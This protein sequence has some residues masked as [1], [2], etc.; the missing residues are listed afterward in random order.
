MLTHSLAQIPCSRACRIV[1]SLPLCVCGLCFTSPFP[2]SCNLDWSAYVSSAWV[3]CLL[4]LSRMLHLRALPP[5]N[6]SFPYYFCLLILILTVFAPTLSH[7]LPCAC[8]QYLT[9][10]SHDITFSYSHLC[11]CLF[12][13][14]SLMHCI[15]VSVTVGSHAISYACLYCYL[16]LVCLCRSDNRVR[17]VYVAIA[18]AFLLH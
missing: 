18:L 15:Y 16:A 2:L 5:F 4:T 3:L 6:Q 8:F 13:C 1:L 11:T 17:V 7:M 10:P 14:M 9:S 12:D